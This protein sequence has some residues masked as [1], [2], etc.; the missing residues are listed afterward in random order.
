MK[1]AHGRYF[2]K[3]R[4]SIH[5]S[6]WTA[7]LQKIHRYLRRLT[8]RLWRLLLAKPAIPDFLPKR[9]SLSLCLIVDHDAGGGANAF[10]KQFVSK[11]LSRGD[12]VLL[13]QYFGG[14]HWYY[15]EWRQEH[16]CS[17]FRAHGFEQA[18]EFVSAASPEI[19]F[20]NNMTGWPHLAETLDL[21]SSL[22]QHGSQLEVFLHDYFTLCPAYPLLNRQG[23]YCGI[24]M[25]PEPCTR[26]LPGHP[27]AAP[28]EGMDITA[29]RTMW[30]HFLGQAHCV[31]APDASVKNLFARVYPEVALDMHIHPHSPLQKW[32]ALPCPT[33]S[34]PPVVGV[35]GHITRHKGAGIVEE[36]VRLIEKR[37]PATRV[38]VIGAFESSICSKVLHV[39][40]PYSYGQLPNLLLQ[41][42]VTVCLVP[43]P[44]P[45][46]FCYTAQEIE[47]LGLPLVCL[48][49]GAQGA[50]AH[51]YAKGF[52]A[53]T[54]DAEGCLDAI[55]R[56]SLWNP[57][58][59]READ[60]LLRSSQRQS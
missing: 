22:G 33:T 52:I 48:N 35:I 1:S 27:L 41:H 56:A 44:L 3:F 60:S 28:H 12:A 21:L 39:A 46:T 4:T 18:V 32:E 17:F 24:P 54:P 16:S 40:G 14:I 47:M 34:S 38:V 11:A 55:I 19:V 59:R 42:Q 51:R 8:S 50:R 6:G 26:C 37:H 9:G 57:S 7:T 5:T 45:E 15:F 43:S 10:R 36:M 30:G 2:H 58:F 53:L 25:P 31:S 13:W 20:F 49:I 29:W 23:T